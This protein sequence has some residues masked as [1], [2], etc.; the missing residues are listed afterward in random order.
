MDWNIQEPQALVLKLRD[1]LFVRPQQFQGRTRYVFEDPLATRF[2][3]VGTAEHM[4]LIQLDG[5]NTIRE[6]TGRAA[7][8]LGPAAF[9]EREALAICRWAVE[10]GLAQPCFASSQPAD[11]SSCGA[12]Q[13][14]KLTFPWNLLAL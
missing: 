7:T 2:F 12:A 14:R 9:Q 13:R 5:R 1:D 6:A 10:C 4:L 8:L 11:E 3:S